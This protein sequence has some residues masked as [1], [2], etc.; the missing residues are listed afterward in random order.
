MSFSSTIASG[1][2]PFIYIFTNSAGDRCTHQFE[3]RN[4]NSCSVQS[5]C[6]IWTIDDLINNARRFLE[7][8]SAKFL[9]LIL[10]QAVP[11]IKLIREAAAIVGIANRLVVEIHQFGIRVHDFRFLDAFGFG[12]AIL[13]F[14]SSQRR[15]T[16]VAI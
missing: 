5:R 2:Q 6:Y 10:R 1:R 3:A 4:R 8:F 16:Q 14:F 12:T 15:T 11:K 7:R 9:L 13:S